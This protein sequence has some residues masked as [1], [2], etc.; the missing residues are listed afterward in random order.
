MAVDAVTVE[1]DGRQVESGHPDKVF[2][3]DRG[4]TKLDLLQRF[5]EGAG[6]P[7]FCRERMPRSAPPWLTTTVVSTPNGTTS[8]ARVAA[9][10]AHVLWAVNLGCLGFHGP[11]GPAA[12]TTPTSCAST[13]IPGRA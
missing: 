2:F 11:T 12:R 1:A 4:D 6:G 5:P 3:A 13:S 10:L 7:S 8:D 9:D